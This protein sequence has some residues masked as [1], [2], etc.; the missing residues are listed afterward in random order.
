[1]ETIAVYWEDK[2]KTYGFQAEHGLSLFRISI[3]SSQQLAGLGSVLDSDINEINFRWIMVQR[4]TRHGFNVYILLDQKWKQPM[5]TLLE[6]HQENNAD[7]DL[8]TESPVEM[9]FFHGPHFGDRYGIAD[10]ALGALRGKSLPVIAMGCT[11]ASVYI[12]LPE[13]CAAKARHFLSAVFET[14]KT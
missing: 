6:R 13:N 5:Q 11:G 1:L 9:I 10:T 8:Q 12:I 2:I 3:P 14:P 7:L 4:S